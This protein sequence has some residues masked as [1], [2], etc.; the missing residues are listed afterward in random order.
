[1]KA[2]VGPVFFSVKAVQAVLNCYFFRALRAANSEGSIGPEL[3]FFSVK[4]VGG[5]ELLFF[6]ALGRN[7]AVVG[8]ELYFFLGQRPSGEVN[9]WSC[10]FGLGG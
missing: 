2:V 4:A 8:P 7:E 5:P 6:R 9:S 10:F 3:V 1:M